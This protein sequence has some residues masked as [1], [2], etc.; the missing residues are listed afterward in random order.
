MDAVRDAIA[1]LTAEDLARVCVPPATPGHPTRAHSMLHC[2]HV[3]L[4]EEW[5]HSRYA[6]RDLDI[7]AA[8]R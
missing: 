3:I 2:L 4:G 1:D 6:N 5:E 8:R 7:L